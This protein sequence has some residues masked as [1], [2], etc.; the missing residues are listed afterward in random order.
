MEKEENKISVVEQQLVKTM[1]ALN[2]GMCMMT[3][4]VLCSAKK[5][6]E[7]DI[8]K[9]SK[10][11]YKFDEAFDKE[12]SNDANVGLSTVVINSGKKLISDLDSLRKKIDKP[13]DNILELL[14]KA[15]KLTNEII[16]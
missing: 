7:G 8:K 6:I 4:F 14:N 12:T 2:L 15:Q 5:E 3:L 11:F 9:A 10:T 13:E 1:T 16:A